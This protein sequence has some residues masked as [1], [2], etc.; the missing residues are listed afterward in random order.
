MTLTPWVLLLA[1]LVHGAGIAAAPPP[2]IETLRAVA[3]LPAH[4]AGAFQDLTACRLAPSGQYFIFDRRSHA[5]FIVPPDLGEARKLIEIGAEP[6]RVIDPSAFDLGPDETFVVADAPRGRPR[7]QI[8]TTSGSSLNAFYLRGRAVPRIAIR[9]HVVSGIGSLEYTGTSV[10]LS[11]PELDSLIT[12]YTARGTP[13]RSFGELRPTRYEADREVH[14]ALNSGLVVANPKGGVYFV[15]LAGVPQFRKYDD[16]GSLVFERHV[17]GVELD[18]F[19]QAL[20]TSWK[21][22]Q[23]ED[24]ELPLVLPSV[25]AAAAD[26]DGNLWISLAPGVTYVYDADGEKR[27]TVQFRSAGVITPTGLSFTARNRVLV[28]PGCYTFA[29]GP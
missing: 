9:N 13:S 21:R 4:I 10:L 12:E 19:I 23:T 25:Y 20:P 14:L 3:A 7:V 6:G 26:H 17:E 1:G 16:A 22:R 18:G 24:G 27:R 15:F 11:Q 8:F 29:T 5:V 2:A 28:T